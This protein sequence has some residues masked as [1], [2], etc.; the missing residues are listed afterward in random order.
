MIEKGSKILVKVAIVGLLFLSLAVTSCRNMEDCY[1]DYFY[2]G[3]VKDQSVNPIGGVEVYFVFGE[4]ISSTVLTTDSAG[5]FELLMSQT[6]A[7]QAGT[8]LK[9]VK[10]GY[11]T[12]FSNPVTN[13][14]GGA[15]VCGYREI[16]RD[17]TLTP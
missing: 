14:E 15:S 17:I 9:F 12:A 13:D 3:T 7:S 1:K 11:T 2:T 6:R 4:N 5:H 8:V 16:K 10:S